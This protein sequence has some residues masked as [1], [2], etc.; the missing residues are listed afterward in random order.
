[1]NAKQLIATVALFAATG[2]TFAQSTEY[3]D[4]AAGF[5]S[6]KTRAEVIGEVKQAHAYGALAQRDGQDAAVTTTAR[7]RAEARAEA[8]QSAQSLRQPIDVNST[9]FGG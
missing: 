8:V 4:P 1:M 7:S 6:T 3:A 9:Y 2:A 5:V